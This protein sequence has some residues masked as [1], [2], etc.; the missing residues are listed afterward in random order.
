MSEPTTDPAAADTPVP[1]TPPTPPPPPNA[2]E[3][4]SVVPAVEAEK[5]EAEKVE[6]PFE[7]QDPFK[8]LAVT[9]V[10]LGKKEDELELYV[11]EMG[12][13]QAFRVTNAVKVIAKRVF[14]KGIV[15][16]EGAVAQDNAT[17]LDNL[18]EVVA[19]S[20]KEII[21]IL[22]ESVYTEYERSKDCKINDE[23]IETL[24]ISEAAILLRAVWHVNWESGSLKNALSGIAGK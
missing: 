1:P 4:L 18:L 12:L 20:E 23:T 17:R 19:E 13:R 24:S 16:K 3:A 5:V 21:M 2:K 6:M 10:T 22:T 15:A 9:K 7:D 14:G 8:R 11:S